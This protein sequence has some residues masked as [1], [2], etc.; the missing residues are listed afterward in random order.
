MVRGPRR[1]TEV[2]HVL[3]GRGFVCPDRH[4]AIACWR[5]LP[6]GVEQRPGDVEDTQAR[7]PEVLDFQGLARDP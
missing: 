5:Q 7:I 1:R 6:E 2:A 3:D 4:E